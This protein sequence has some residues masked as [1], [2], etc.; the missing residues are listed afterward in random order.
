MDLLVSLVFLLLLTLIGYFIDAERKPS[1]K[2]GRQCE[3]AQSVV[4]DAPRRRCV[5]VKARCNW[6]AIH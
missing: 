2:N 6:T 4:P 3:P 1:G 5:S